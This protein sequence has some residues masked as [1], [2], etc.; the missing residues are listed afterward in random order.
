MIPFS[1]AWR[2]PPPLRWRYST[3]TTPAGLDAEFRGNIKGLL[4]L[5]EQAP[6]ADESE[7]PRRG[8]VRQLRIR[9]G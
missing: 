5:G 4:T 6:K 1:T 8:K 3:S 9:N 2:R 7:T